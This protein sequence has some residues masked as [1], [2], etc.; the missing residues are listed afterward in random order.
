MMKRIRH[1]GIVVNDLQR[2]IFFYR[3]LLRLKVQKDNRE[4]G[5]YIDKILGVRSVDVRTVKLSSNDGTLIELLY[6]S[7]AVR[8]KKT[9]AVNDIGYSHIAFSIDNLDEE[10]EKL[11][12]Q[13]INF[14]SSPQV[15]PDN[16]AKVAFCKDPDG[17]FIELVEVLNRD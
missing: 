4:K 10:Y 12:K 17:N 13:G 5:S 8:R 2:S 15:S 14:I 9:K 1:I 16:Y 11:K 3:D 6:Y 7:P